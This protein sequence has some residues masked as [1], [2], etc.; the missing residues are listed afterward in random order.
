MGNE[1]LDDL[2]QA[3]QSAL[4][5][6][7]ASL[8]NRREEAVR[9]MC[10]ADKTES[11]QSFFALAVPQNGKD[12][13]KYKVVALPA[14]SFRVHHRPQISLLSLAFECEL[15]E[16]KLPGASQ[17]YSLIITAGNRR[18]WPHKKRRQMQIV[19]HGTDR[20]SGEVRLDGRLL[21]E[22][23]CYSGEGRRLSLAKT[24]PTFFSKLLNQLWNL[25]RRQRYIMTV[26]QSQR[27]R[28]I[29]RQADTETLP[30][31]ETATL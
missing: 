30:C 9:R 25:G 22:I 13:G 27:V 19:F 11:A 10:E 4:L 21:V 12:E 20:A 7:Q 24:K 1:S 26:E 5:A 29:L 15:K 23:P 3:L 16:K 2:L 31:Y 17:V 6:A 8:K 14:S 28:E 18:R